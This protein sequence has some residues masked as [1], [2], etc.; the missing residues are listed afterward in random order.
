[1]PGVEIRTFAV[2][3]NVSPPRPF[4]PPHT[5][6]WHQLV[7][8]SRGVMTVSAGNTDWLLIP[9]R[10]LWIPARTAYTIRLTGE[11]A[12]RCLYFRTVQSFE[13]PFRTCAA[14]NVTPLFRELI[15]RAS[16]MGAL[17]RF[18]P[19]ERRLIALIRDEV[20]RLRLAPLELPA[21]RDS[22]A[23][24]F[25]RLVGASPP[26]DRPPL[27]VIL[28]RCGTS[29]RT[30]ERVFRAE[31]SMSLGRW[32]RRH[33]LL[34]AL[35]H[36]TAGERVAEVSDLLGYGSPSAFIAMFRRELGQSPSKHLRS[37]DPLLTRQS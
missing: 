34:I 4:V 8:A 17:S 3:F 29:Q 36:L 9:N 28:R 14:L 31:T 10:A 21:P 30:M 26:L 2:T 18:D 19:R 6:D 15:L 20:Q 25:A 23:A 37:S 12:L 33:D 1:M 7:Y 22:R 13:K 32:M 24:Q 5:H 16:A 35:R 11:V 27:S